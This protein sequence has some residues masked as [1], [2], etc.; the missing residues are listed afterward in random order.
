MRVL[1]FHPALAPYRVDFFNELGKRMNLRVV[2]MTRNN[3]NQAFNQNELLRDA[4]YSYGYLDRHHII[5][6]RN[7]NFGYSEEIRNFKPDIVICN[8]FGISLWVS[9]LI[10]LS[11]G[12]KY[13]LLTICDDSEDVFNNR[14]SL[15]KTVTQFFTKHINEIIC[16]NPKVAEYYKLIG[17]KK[18]SFFPIIYKNSLFCE[19]LKSSIPTTNDYIKRFNL[20]GCK[21]LLFVG[22]F[23]VVKNLELLIKAF[24]LVTTESS[25]EIRLIL[26]GDGEL[27]QSLINQ[28]KELELDSKVVFPGR[29]E[30]NQLLAW[31]NLKGSCVLIST[32]ERFGAVIAEARMAGMP[33]LVS[34]KG[35]AKCLITANNGMICHSDNVED[36]AVKMKKI[37]DLVEPVDCVEKTNDSIIPYD[38]DALMDELIKNLQA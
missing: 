3:A 35:G 29:Y 2:F 16:I 33:A 21:C 13:K 14:T 26:V 6:K 32:H 17:A 15:R 20:K 10:K 11:Q 5:F 24:S 38:F 12:K 34:D 9:Y 36:I 7:I 22:R 19:R 25:Q 37:L 8:E 4:T 31:Y 23:T 18:T 1:I 30:G 28:S 27:K